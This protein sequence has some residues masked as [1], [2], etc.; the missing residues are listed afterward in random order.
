MF[1]GPRVKIQKLLPPAIP[2]KIL[3]C[4][5]KCLLCGAAKGGLTKVGFG[6]KADKMSPA[7]PLQFIV[8]EF[9]SRNTSYHS[10]TKSQSP[11]GSS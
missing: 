3:S 5:N 7:E 1:V 11:F 2:R 9:L 6:R 10:T 8:A 4:E